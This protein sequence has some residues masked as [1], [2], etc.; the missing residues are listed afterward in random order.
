MPI[1]AISTPKAIFAREK[2]VKLTSAVKAFTSKMGVIGAPKKSI[3][4]LSRIFRAFVSTLALFGMP[5][6][7]PK[8]R[9]PLPRILVSAPSAYEAV[10]PRLK[11][12]GIAIPAPGSPKARNSVCLLRDSILSLAVIAA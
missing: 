1:C 6:V 3:A 11:M 8:S 10:A 12:P 2:A 4:L 9:T 7:R 5:A